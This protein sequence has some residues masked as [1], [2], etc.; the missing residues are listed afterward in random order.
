MPLWRLLLFCAGFALSAGVAMAQ[1]AKDRHDPTP[2]PL[3]PEAS[4]SILSVLPEPGPSIREKRDQLQDNGLRFTGKYIGEVFANATGG[5]RT[6]TAYDGRFRLSLD[7]DFEKL[8]GAQGL[9][10]HASALQIH[11]RGIDLLYVGSLMPPSNIEASRATRLYELWLQ[12]NFLDG[13]FSIRAGQIAVD[14]EFMFPIW[15][16]MF[17]NGAFGWPVYAAANL[18][19]G[20][21]AYPL[22]ST[23]VRVAFNPSEHLTLM[24][25]ALNGD[26]AP[27]MGVFGN[28]DPQR[29]NPSGL[30]F[31]LSDPPLFLG[32]AQIKYKLNDLDG[33]IK[34]GGWR[35]DG[36]FALQHWGVDSLSLADPNSIGV[37]RRVRGNYGFYAILDQEIGAGIGPGRGA[38]FFLRA[39][40]VPNDRNL[41]DLSAD[42]G[43]SFVG[44]MDSRPDDLFG[45]GFGYT[46]ISGS[47][48]A[49]DRD[50]AFFNNP[51]QPV[52]SSEELAEVTYI[53]NMAP[54]WYVQ[55]DVQFIRQ[56][57]GNIPDPRDPAGVLPLRNSLVFGLRTL[58]RF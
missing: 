4:R 52:R 21:P 48:R 55:P 32:E 1:V 19:D 45:V 6:G 54:G 46:R 41:V 43:V 22:A 44:F 51:L 49:L 56:P 3:D 10:L 7:A 34:L 42:A 31:R 39:G 14:Q 53:A 33:V 13:V 47:A 24:A 58:V 25:A 12:K 20:G 5:F 23:G 50:A 35:H 36:S 16:T 11:G 29:R 28:P 38:G 30:M 18:P 15:A 8:A 27:P 9:V 37:A 2:P 17:I 57:G 26:A 40:M